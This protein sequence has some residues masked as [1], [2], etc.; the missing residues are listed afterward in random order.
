MQ[1]CFSK[2][3]TKATECEAL[4][5]KHTPHVTQRQAALLN[6]KVTSKGNCYHRVLF[7]GIGEKESE[8][9]CTLNFAFLYKSL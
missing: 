3:R 1:A 8:Y 7:K 2:T 4:I 5:H 9:K 6:T